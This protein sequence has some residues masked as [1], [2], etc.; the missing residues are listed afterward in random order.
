MIVSKGIRWSAILEEIVEPIDFNYKRRIKRKMIE[1]TILKNVWN[2]ATT[3]V[4]LSPIAATKCAVNVVPIFAPKTIIAANSIGNSLLANKTA[5]VI[6]AEE[7]WTKI[8]NIIPKATNN[9]LVK[10]P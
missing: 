8:V 5:I 6:E 7:K 10:K 1:I 3:F 9:K 2:A 4:Y